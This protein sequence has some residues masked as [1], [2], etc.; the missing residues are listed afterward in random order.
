MQGFDVNHMYRSSLTKVFTAN[1]HITTVRPILRRFAPKIRFNKE[2]STL[3][4][5]NLQIQAHIAV[6]LK[7]LI[8]Y[9]GFTMHDVLDQDGCALIDMDDVFTRLQT[10]YPHQKEDI[11]A[12]IVPGFVLVL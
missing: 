12:I 7:F 9:D 6:L 3:D 8:L 5:Y 10:R 2:V 11:N 1:H 4:E